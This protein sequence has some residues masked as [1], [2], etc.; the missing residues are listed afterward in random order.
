MS[1]LKI[2]DP[3][4]RDSIFQEFL[5]TK[6]NI[7]QNCLAEKMGDIGMQAELAKLYKPITESQAAQSAALTREIVDL[8]QS[9]STALQALPASS[10][11]QLRPIQ[12]P[13]YPSITA[14]LPAAAAEETT[15]ELGPIA[16][17]YLRSHVSKSLTDKTFDLFDR[18]DNFFIGDSVVTIS[19]DDIIIGDTTYKG[20]KRLWELIT[21]KNPNT[22]KYNNDDLEKY[23]DILLKTKAIE[24]TRGRTA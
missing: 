13:N 2:T 14:G 3:A 15:L 5:N 12:F 19:G 17:K 21:S 22:E 16:T 20:T 11:S 7:Q 8:K 10:S 18:N 23:T 9:T 24:D 6:K 4:K 1:F